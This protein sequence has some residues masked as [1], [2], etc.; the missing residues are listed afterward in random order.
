MRFSLNEQGVK[1]VRNF[2]IVFKTIYKESIKTKAFLNITIG[3]V[4]LSLLLFASPTLISYFEKNKPDETY[5]IVNGTDYR[6][7]L[8]NFRSLMVNGRLPNL[9]ICVH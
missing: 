1:K 8:K 9:I 7:S 2:M 6:Y 4:L 3:L 5:K